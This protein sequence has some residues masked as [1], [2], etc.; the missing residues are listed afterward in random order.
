MTLKR[1]ALLGASLQALM[2]APA[3][4]QVSIETETTEP[5]ATSTANNGA[6]A[7]IEITS[8]GSIAL[9]ESPGVTAVTIDTSNDFTNDGVVTITNSD[10]VVGLRIGP[11]L[12]TDISG[13]G[14]IA[15]TDDYEREDTDEDD[16]LDGPLAT[17]SNRIGVLLEEGGAMSGQL[18]L[19]TVTVTGNDS[20]AVSLRSQMDGDLEV[21]TGLSVTGSNGL[22]LDVREGVDGDVRITGTLRAQ[23]ENSTAARI[24]GD[25][26]GEFQ[27]NGSILATGFTSTS[28]SNY[29]DPDELEEDDTPIADRRDPDDLLVGGPAL[30]INSSLNRGLLINGAADGGTDPTDDE[31]DVVQDFNENRT[32]GSVAS[33]G[34]APALLISAPDGSNNDL[35]LGLVRESV[36]DT[37]DDDEDEDTTE[38]IGVFDY[39]YGLINRGTISAN[40]LNIGFDST[41]L[42]L[43]GAS[44]GSADTIITGGI[45]NTGSITSLA[46]EADATA[47]HIGDGTQTP[48]FTNSSSIAATTYTEDQHQA[49]GVL[50]ESGASL[51]SFSNTGSIT[52]TVR[53]YD[54]SPVAFRDESGTLTTFTN[55]SRITAGYIDDD[56]ED[57]ITSGLG[58]AIALDFR[59]GNGVTITQTDIVDNA[60]IYGDILLSDGDDVVNLLSGL[61]QGDIEFGAGSDVLNASSGNFTGTALFSGSLATI[62][63]SQGANVYADI[64]LSNAAPLFTLASASSYQGAIY[65]GAASGGALTVSGATFNNL[66]TDT[67]L[68]DTI[69]LSNGAN[70]GVYIDST[71]ASGE[72][73]RIV[74]SGAASVASDTIFTPIFRN[75]ERDGFTVRVLEAGQLD[76][77]G[78]LDAMLNASSSFFFDLDLE[79]SDTGDA[80]DLVGEIKTPQSLGLNTR[81]S[82]AYESVID[83]VL[84]DDEAASSIASIDGGDAFRRAYSD[85]MPS[86]SATILRVLASNSASSFG[87]TARRLNLGYDTPTIE[88]GLW[89]EEYGVYQSVDATAEANGISAGGYGLAIGLDLFTRPNS[90]IGVFG[91]L[92]NVEA[93]EHGRSAA[94]MGVASRAIGT[95]G[96]VRLGDTQLSASTSYGFLTFK[97]NRRY[98][99]GGEDQEASADWSGGA[100]SGNLNLTHE[101]RAGRISVRPFAGAEYM[102]LNEDA[103]AETSLEDS[104]FNLSVSDATSS[105]AT[106]SAGARIAA[107]FGNPG[108][109]L[110]VPELTLGYRSVLDYSG[111][112][113]DYLFDGG[114]GAEAFR[115]ADEAAPED[116]FLAGFGLKLLNDGF[117][118]TLGYDAEIGSSSLTHYGTI[119]L[120]AVL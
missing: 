98:T 77:E 117:D 71:A 118:F 82:Q 30:Q 53:G 40:G 57:D 36:R 111:S 79:L 44:D 72:N 10:N 65:G 33:Y 54:G 5:V 99:I 108:E 43:Q 92:D 19:G 45:H 69:D 46:Y 7:D 23:G 51:P 96:S 41:A 100:F 37:L 17:G 16:D 113:A 93:E 11:G 2:I 67:L 101:F 97:S 21:Q 107:T 89:A 90:T 42:K 78:D 26:T 8:N 50:I 52:A 86:Q 112:D 64:N 55:Q 28:I 115:F 49:I 31:K 3:I 88:R 85:L 103:Y 91:T 35:V 106:A 24:S 70:V 20:A 1:A 76:L 56:A 32:A 4:A 81:Q 47:I 13:V 119:A 9:E 75:Y 110:Y 83:L 59:A 18:Q 29:A 60:R 25:V 22:A 73:S 102:L 38:I 80:I 105:L 12:T 39:E 84:N 120:R 15:L 62:E 68:V 74:V 116:A 87:A 34:S 58:R 61:I 48:R 27:I 114:S 94:P 6:A 66:T 63:L 104:P 14:A 109:T 95:Y